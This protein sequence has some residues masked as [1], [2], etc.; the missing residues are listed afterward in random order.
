MHEGRLCA[1]GFVLVHFFFFD[2][3]VCRGE[4]SMLVIGHSIDFE[5]FYHCFKLGICF[6]A[7]LQQI[8]LSI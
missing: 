2:V 1:L 8:F 7:N 6:Q 4:D 3:A 5:V